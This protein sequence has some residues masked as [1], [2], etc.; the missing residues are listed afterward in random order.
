MGVVRNSKS[1]I[2]RPPGQPE[3]LLVKGDQG[4]VNGKPHR[5]NGMSLLCKNVQFFCPIINIMLNTIRERAHG[6]F[7]G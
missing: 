2:P 4:W 1:K 7:G 3:V 6:A 5:A